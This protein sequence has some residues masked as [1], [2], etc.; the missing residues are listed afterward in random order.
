MVK[1]QRQVMEGREAE[2]S[3]TKCMI[4]GGAAALLS[5]SK[6]SG[7][8]SVQAVKTERFSL[9][10]V[11]ILSRNS[12]CA[13]TVLLLCNIQLCKQRHRTDERVGDCCPEGGKYS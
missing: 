12:W 8:E 1:N 11:L 3:M 7:E 10:Q 9:E 2:R 6:L 4:L 13:S 5:S